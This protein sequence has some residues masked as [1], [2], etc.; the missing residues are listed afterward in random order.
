M[1]STYLAL[2]ACAGVGGYL[3]VDG[4]APAAAPAKPSRGVRAA[5]LPPI[6]VAPA[7]PADL[8]EDLPALA[9]EDMV[10]GLDVEEPMRGHD[11]ITDPA[12]FAMVFSLDGVTYLR[13]STEA[14]AT[15]HGTPQL[16]L[17]GEVHAVVAPVSTSSLPAEFRSWAGKTVL[18]NGTCRA[19]VV[20]FA[21]VSRITGEPSDPFRYDDDGNPIEPDEWTIEA[22]TDNN[23]MLAAKL[24]DACIGTWARAEAFS[25]AAIASMEEVPVLEF[26][27][28]AQLFESVDEELTASWKEQGGEGSWRD[29]A[30][31]VSTTWKHPLTNERWVFV[32]A[33]RHGSCG[34]PGF[35]K[36]AA[37]RVRADASLHHAATLDYGGASISEILDLDGDGQPELLLGE[38]DTA[39]VDLTNQAQQSIY[40]PYH[41]YGCGC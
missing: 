24:D 40:I 26:E 18:V 39:L 32:Q 23:V 13:L 20:G 12:E 6:V 36:M 7:R 31:V 28:K 38:G 14:R 8:D 2:A 19:Q 21:E 34:D 17:D 16:L 37:Y 30:D 22:V 9:G 35:S 15:R 10:D 5:K 25:P 11:E 33:R 29:A 27:A 41:S 3:L 1:R 4:D